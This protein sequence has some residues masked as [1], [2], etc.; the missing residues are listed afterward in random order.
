MGI[1]KKI[2]T[3]LILFAVAMSVLA[4]PQN[5]ILKLEPVAQTS[6]KT[7]VVEMI[8]HDVTKRV[9]RPEQT[10]VD[11]NHF[12]AQA[13]HAIR[14]VQNAVKETITLDGGVFLVEPE[15]EAETREWYIAVE[16][17]GYTFRLCWYGPA[18]DFTGTF[19]FDDISWDWTWGWYQSADLFYEIFPS[20]INMTISQQKV[21][22]YLTQIILDATI[23]DTNDNIYVL[24]IVHE[25]FTPKSTVETVLENAQLTIGEGYYVLDGNNNELDLQLT[26]NSST[27]DGLYNKDYFDLNATKITYDGVEQQLLQA[28]LM[29]TG[30]TL[31]NGSLGYFADLS[32]YNQDTIL[33]HVSMQASLPAVKDTIEVVCTNLQ[34][35]E[36]LGSFGL[37]MVSGSNDFYDVFAMYEGE[38]ADAG[39]YNVS[40]SITD[41]ITWLEPTEAITATLT[42]TEETDG[43]HANIEAYGKDYN[44]Y[45]IDMS[46]VVPEPTDTVDITFETTAIGTYLPYDN[47]MLQLLHYGDD[48]E[49]SLTVYGKGLGDSF[50][51][52][53]VYL[54]Y[55]GIYNKKIGRSVIFAD[56]NGTLNQYGDTTVISASVI[57]FDA[58]QYNLHLWYV[59]PTPTDTVEIEMPIEFINSMDYGYYTLGAYTPDSVWYVSLSPI[60]NEVAGSF[61]ND[62]VFGRLGSEGGQYDFYGGETYIYEEATLNRYSVEKGTLIVE[63]TP[64]GKITAE[65]K[66]ICSNAI[67]YHIKMTSEYNT[68]LDFDEPEEIIDRVYTTED[69]VF[70]ENQV[71]ANGYIYLALTAGDE[72]DMAAFF[73]YTE[74][75]DEDIIIPVGVYPINY[76]EEYGTVQA[77][78]GVQ[79]NGVLPSFYA[80]V[81]EDGSLE[82]PL[83]LLVGGTVEVR[84]DEQLNAHLEVNAY[85]SYG[86]PVHIVF[87]GTPTALPDTRYPI[88]DTRKILQNGQLLI[89]RNGETYNAIGNRL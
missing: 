9:A 14:P 2:S 31:P 12:A 51:M 52:D 78:P 53:N 72:S 89:I 19:S 66:V 65:A 75:V 86:V 44:W 83:W 37:I 8:K 85:N 56:V 79:G 61:A 20:D 30:G 59:A 21:S 76:T 84:K 33:H 24:H 29:I 42:L 11:D 70:I 27:I 22:N 54:D 35:D 63:M 81:W 28:T 47:N 77:N 46:Y 3:V 50:T 60:T 57:G 26:V 38:Y 36:S 13:K 74:E 48:Y 34:V 80:K 6:V 71:E 7:K 1:M 10:N 39:V 67:Y 88:S 23:T 73:F 17:H 4:L 25:M 40:V 49:A 68:H 41:K 69:N 45:S 32:F 58:V 62:G 55:S 82:V 18:D 5:K 16:S 87:D 43:W 15:Y 64:D